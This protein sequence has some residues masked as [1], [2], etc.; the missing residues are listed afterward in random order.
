MSAPERPESL[1]GLLAEFEG[2]EALL[3]AAEHV[4]DA[5]YR[6]WDVHTP[7]PVHGMDAAMGL[8]PTILPWLVFGAG[9]TGCLGALLLQWWTN[10][11]NYPFLISGKPFFGLPA[12]IPVAF[13]LTILLASLAAFFGMLGLN[14]LPEWYHSLF[15]SKRFHRVTT[16][17]FFLSVE[18]SD[19]AFDRKGTAELLGSLGAVHVEE[20]E[21]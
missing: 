6:R 18:A 13:E 1:Y 5:G 4:R 8:R 19:A 10:A 15:K 16:D 12:A 7:F 11:V 2:P 20:V 17:G 9:A 14:R 3:F 21:D